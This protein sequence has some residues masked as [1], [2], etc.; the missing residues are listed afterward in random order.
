VLFDQPNLPGPIPFLHSPFAPDRIFGVV[1][2][3]K[4][5]EPH[6]IVFPREA[7]D[8]LQP[9]FYNAADEVVGNVDVKRPS[10]SA[11]KNV[12]VEIACSYLTPLEYWMPRLRGA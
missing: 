10:G 6:D 5:H 4:V 3:F 7:V 12:D 11:G 9:M 1:E 8:Q 2:L